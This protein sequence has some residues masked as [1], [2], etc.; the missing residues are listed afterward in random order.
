MGAHRRVSAVNAEI[1]VGTLPEKRFSSRVLRHNVPVRTPESAG[2]PHGGSGAYSLFSLVSAVMLA[3]IGPVKAFLAKSLIASS[4]ACGRTE[5]A[6]NFAAT[7][8]QSE[9]AVPYRREPGRA[10]GRTFP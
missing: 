9:S 4:E 10:W 7:R 2:R 3:G 1:V 5:R 8:S 6:A